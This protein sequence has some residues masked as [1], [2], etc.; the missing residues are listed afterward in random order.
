MTY[1]KID[2]GDPIENDEDV[3][4]SQLGKT[5]VEPSY[6]KIE[7]VS[8]CVREVGGQCVRGGGERSGGGGGGGHVCVRA[9]GK[10]NTR[11]WRSK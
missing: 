2:R 8:V 9:P 6:R 7:G 10:R 5:E 11:I 3:L 1:S 4:I